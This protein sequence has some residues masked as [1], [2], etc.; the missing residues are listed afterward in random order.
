MASDCTGREF[1][2][3]VVEVLMTDPSWWVAIRHYLSE[4][5]TW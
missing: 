2:Q 3:M 5:I 1:I 4:E